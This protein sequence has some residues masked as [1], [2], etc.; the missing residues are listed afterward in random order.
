MKIQSIVLVLLLVGLA[1]GCKPTAQL[2]SAADLP[3]QAPSATPLPTATPAPTESPV[4]GNCASIG[5]RTQNDG[6]RLPR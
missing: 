4:L 6:G 2:A 1:T 3:T 5:G